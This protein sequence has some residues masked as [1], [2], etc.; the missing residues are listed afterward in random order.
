MKIQVFRNDWQMLNK[1]QIINLF[2]ANFFFVTIKPNLYVIKKLQFLEVGTLELLENRSSSTVYR[3]RQTDEVVQIFQPNG[4]VFC[5]DTEGYFI[6]TP[7]DKLLES[8]EAKPPVFTLI[9]RESE[10]CERVVISHK[11]KPKFKAIFLEEEL[12][13][14]AWEE[15][16]PQDEKEI[17]KLM[18]KAEA[19]FNSYLK[20]P[21]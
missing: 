16:P 3:I 13:G 5:F 14:I 6:S 17:F 19:F 2:D 21:T 1:Q 12:T 11:M 10:E 15:T 8:Y 7:K 18:R 4:E 9:S 20:K